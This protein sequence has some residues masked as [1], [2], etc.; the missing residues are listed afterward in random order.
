MS[1]TAMSLAR[2]SFFADRL[3]RACATFVLLFLTAC[4]E[5]ET[6]DAPAPDGG[7][8]IAKL[9][10]C[11][12]ACAVEELCVEDRD[13]KYGCARICANQLRCWSGCCLPL[14]DTGYNVCRPNNYCYAE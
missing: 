6:V 2:R 5:A 11:A 10:R 9:D 8:M 13:G 14:G 7:G 3:A 4:D 12:G 1:N